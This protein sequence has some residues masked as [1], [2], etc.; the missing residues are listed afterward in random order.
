MALTADIGTPQG[1]IRPIAT[2]ASSTNVFAGLNRVAGMFSDVM[3]EQTRAAA[4]A[5]ASQERAME[6]ARQDRQEARAIAGEQRSIWDFEQ[7]KGEAEAKDFAA[8]LMLN[9]NARTFE[10]QQRPDKTIYGEIDEIKI[11]GGSLG[12]EG[13]AATVKIEKV[14]KALAQGRVSQTVVD[15]QTRNIIDK[16]VRDNPDKA[17]EFAD[18]LKARGVDDPFVRSIE[19]FRDAE[20]WQKEQERFADKTA[21]DAAAKNG[22]SILKEDG[23]LDF[24]ATRAEGMKILQIEAQY[25]VESRRLANL[26]T[27]ADITEAGRAA[28]EEAQ[29]D[30]AIKYGYQWAD[31]VT[32]STVVSL[33]SLSNGIRTRE[34]GQRFLTESVPLALQ[35]LATARSRIIQ[36]SGPDVPRAALE[37][38]LAE[39][40]KKILAVKDLVSGDASAVNTRI[41]ALS[42][43]QT[44]MGLDKATTWPLW[45]FYSNIYG[46]G[47]LVEAVTGGNIASLIPPEDMKALRQQT[48]TGVQ[49]R[50]GM[51]ASLA[52]SNTA[53]ILSNSARLEDLNPEQQRKVLPKLIGTTRQHAQAIVSTGGGP[54]N[55]TPFI[56]SLAGV[57][58]AVSTSIQPSTVTLDSFINATRGLTAGGAA[59][60]NALTASALISLSKVPGYDDEARAL[61]N[62]VTIASMQLINGTDKLKQ[63]VSKGGIYEVKFNNRNSRYEVVVNQTAL[64]AAVKKNR[65]LSTAVFPDAV[66]AMGVSAVQDIGG[67]PPSAKEAT[68]LVNTLNNLVGNMAS[69]RTLDPTFR[70]QGSKISF[71]DAKAYFATGKVPVALQTMIQDEKSADQKFNEASTEF[72]KAAQASSELNLEQ[73]G[74]AI[75]NSSIDGYIRKTFFRESSNNPNAA[76]DTSSAVGKGQFLD[77]TWLSYYKKTFPDEAKGLTKAQI[78]AKRTDEESMMGVMKTFTLDNAD[79]IRSIGKPVNDTN[80]YLYHFLGAGDAPKVLRAGPNT[81]IATLVDP[82]SIAANPDVFKGINTVADMIRWAE[83]K[84]S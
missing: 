75:E 17:A 41:K 31:S 9:H 15:L 34:Q 76:A 49:T 44:Q 10:N 51:Q 67:G 74:T 63:E 12:P 59:G 72:A 57:T 48:A 4:R 78:L 29:G 16:Y 58:N 33:M 13:T 6:N 45:S 40:D 50:A 37:T 46:Q 71:E 62:G 14:Y 43:F 53:L 5:Q 66:Q 55:Y 47:A 77:A 23:S 38:A 19:A 42:L 56:A 26:K 79:K 8:Q 52:A 27:A 3:D 20:S 60:S 68:A 39:V 28:A 2:P 81:P 54:S 24:G 73:R 84:M 65:N 1:T 22:I 32:N 61:A 80:L 35:S 82:D 21:L 69:L 36:Q 18:A 30:L 25:T 11:E 70:G 64:A 83:R 7:R